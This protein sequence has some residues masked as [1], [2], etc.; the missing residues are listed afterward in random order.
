MN[1]TIPCCKVWHVFWLKQCLA[2]DKNNN[3]SCGRVTTTTTTRTRRRRKKEYPKYFNDTIVILNPNKSTNEHL[4]K[5][6][7]FVLESQHKQ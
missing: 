2:N 4:L 6:N 3:K 5:K 7:I 1:K